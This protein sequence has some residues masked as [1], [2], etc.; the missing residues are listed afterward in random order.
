[1]L[2]FGRGFFIVCLATAERTE[3]M[4]TDFERFGGDETSRQEK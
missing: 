2:V 1:M 3:V 4:D